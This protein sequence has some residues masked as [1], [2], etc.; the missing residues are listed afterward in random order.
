VYVLVNQKSATIA[1]LWDGRQLKVTLRR[2]FSNKLLLEWYEIMKIAQ[3]LNLSGEEDSVVWQYEA[4][5]VYSVSS[6]YAIINFTGVLPVY[7]QAV[8]K[9]KLPPKIHLFLWLVSHNKV[10]TRDNLVKRQNIDDLTCVFCS[11]PESNLYLFFE[12]SVAKVV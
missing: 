7:V 9:L 3:T 8:W 12:C 1:K 10:L 6:L 5:G 4:S 2:C 11:E